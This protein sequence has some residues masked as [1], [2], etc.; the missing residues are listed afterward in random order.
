M[1]ASDLSYRFPNAGYL[2]V[3]VFA[4]LIL[5]WLYSRH[6]DKMFQRYANPPVLPR[7]LIPQPRSNYWGK[8]I[9]FCFVWILASLA[10]MQPRGGARYPEG[11]LYQTPEANQ[12]PSEET[13][14]RRLKAHEIILLIDASAS[15]NVS[16]SRDG[17]TRLTFAKDIADQI[18]SR[19]NGESVSLYAFTSEVTKLV[20]PTMDYIFTRLMLR[21][22]KINE[23]DVT[24]TDIVAALAKM[25]DT[26]WTK[27]SSMLKTLILLTDGGD[28]YLETLS[29][30][31]KQSQI[32]GILNFL[33]DPE[34]EHLR[35]FTVG[36]GTKAG[37]DVPDITYEGHPVHSALDDDLLKKLAE[38][39]RGQYYAANNFTSPDL[40]SNLMHKL[41]EDKDIFVEEM[42]HEGRGKG[43]AENL[44]YDLYFQMPLGLAILF[45]GLA[46]F[47]PKTHRVLSSSGLKLKALCLF[48]LL[49]PMALLNADA[50]ASAEFTLSKAAAY[51]D[52]KAYAKAEDL[53]KGLLQE[54]LSSWQKDVVK[55]NLGS[56]LLAEGQF[57]KALETFQNISLDLAS[58]PLLQFRVKNNMAV[59]QLRK[60]LML[61]REIESQPVNLELLYQQCIISLQKTLSAIEEAEKASCALSRL[62]GKKI[63]RLIPIWKKCIFWQHIRW[64]LLSKNCC[65]K[66]LRMLPLRKR[67]LISLCL[68]KP[69]SPM[70]SY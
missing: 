13:F 23:G 7:M 3:G 12:K 47:M 29:E 49:L 51:F 43:E 24:G 6:R 2:I 15:M 53:Y 22:V 42:G 44:V 57:D 33:G 65:K 61:L 17:Q 39:G 35:V 26:Y 58:S 59:A 18:V 70:S 5:F 52:A 34:A 60:A 20:P 19:L 16:D 56:A 48:W 32:D 14:V 38:R 50:P 45:L 62:E 36:M 41:A 4:W 40:A 28:T 67:L 64:P 69:L 11:T 30:S 31:D 27:P 10:L 25:R 1:I 54:K 8:T 66:K 63:A 37:Q 9:A 55:Y 21:G 46:L 68:S